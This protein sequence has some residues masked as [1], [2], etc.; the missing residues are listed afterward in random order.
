MI[1]IEKRIIEVNE[2]QFKDEVISLLKRYSKINKSYIAIG[3]KSFKEE[4]K[5]KI[6]ELEFLELCLKTGLELHNNKTVL[7]SNITLN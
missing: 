2:E 5:L 4:L 3:F 6:T 1:K 7:I